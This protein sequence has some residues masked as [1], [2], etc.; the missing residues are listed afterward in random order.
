MTWPLP[1]HWGWHLPQHSRGMCVVEGRQEGRETLERRKWGREGGRHKGGSKGE[2]GA[3]LP[4]P[5]VM[6][7]CDSPRNP[8]CLPLF[9][10]LPHVAQWPGLEAEIHPTLHIRTGVLLAESFTIY[11]PRSNLS[12]GI[13]PREEQ[14][15]PSSWCSFFPLVISKQFY[16][17]ALSL[18]PERKRKGAGNI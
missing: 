9:S 7:A 14:H 13:F 4:F 16:K 15:S 3:L 10:H 12:Q 6:I 5:S 8:F 1:V 11:T 17:Q 2:N 18:L